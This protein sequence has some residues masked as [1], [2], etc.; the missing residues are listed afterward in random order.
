MKF[1][2]VMETGYEAVQTSQIP[3]SR[4]NEHQNRNSGIDWSLIPSFK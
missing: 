2:K 4:M 3:N 1:T